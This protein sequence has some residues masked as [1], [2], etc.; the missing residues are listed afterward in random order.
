[1]TREAVDL[2]L[3]AW[4]ATGP[5]DWHGEFWH[6]EQLHIIPQPLTKLHM[7]VGMA[8][9]AQRGHAGADRAKRL[10]PAD[11]LDAST[12]AIEKHDRNLSARR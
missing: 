7:E 5:F 9:S 11:E 1:M 4:T 6:G 3:T 2:I 12:R 10:H 8:R